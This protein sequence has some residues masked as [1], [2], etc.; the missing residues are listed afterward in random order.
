MAQSLNTKKDSPDSQIASFI[1]K[2]DPA[3]GKLVRAAR[4]KLRKRFASAVELVY[5]N[6]NALVIGW[7]PTDRSTDAILSLAA[8]AS[9][10]NLY[11][12]Q[13]AQLR[14]PQKVLQGKG[15]QGRFVRLET[16]TQLDTPA[17][18]T[19]IDDAIKQSLVPLAKSGRSY[20]VIKSISLK[21][22]PRRAP[23]K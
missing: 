9:G 3:I 10:V 12:I 17:I 5:D 21:Q 6:Y 13:G 7:G 14:D 11:F 2:F 19:L 15:N 8:Y 1:A 20:T 4:A 16:V 18:K 23:V 22:R